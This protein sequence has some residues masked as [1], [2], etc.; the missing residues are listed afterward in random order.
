[1]VDRGGK[2]RTHS[3][4]LPCST[5]RLDVLVGALSWHMDGANQSIS[6]FHVI[7][8]KNYSHWFSAL[9]FFCLFFGGLSVS[10]ITLRLT[11]TVTWVRGGDVTYNFP[12]FCVCGFFFF[13][14][15]GGCCVFSSSF[16]SFVIFLLRSVF[17]IT[18]L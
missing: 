4:T 8:S 7:S 13:L 17:Y 15:G 10:T 2:Q 18:I 11:C 5:N 14:G 16:S 6:T 12:L 9:L 3:P 1:M